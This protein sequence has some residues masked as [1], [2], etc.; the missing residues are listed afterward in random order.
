[1]TSIKQSF[2]YI[3][4]MPMLPAQ[5]VI[6]IDVALPHVKLI[7]AQKF[8]NKISILRKEVI[9]CP[10]YSEASEISKENLKEEIQKKISG[11][12]QYPVAI[13]LPQ[14]VSLSQVIDLP[15]A[16]ESDVKRMIQGEAHRIA[17]LS[18]TKIVWDYAPLRPYGKH[19]H[20]FWIS[21]CQ[22]QEI[23]K[24]IEKLG[25]E[26]EEVREVMSVGNALIC[27]YL[28]RF[29]ETVSTIIVEIGT[30]STTVAI[31]YEG[32]GVYVTSFALGVE[33]LSE[34]ISPQSSATNHFS[35]RTEILLKKN[36]FSGSDKSDSYC[37]AIENWLQEL[38]RIVG[39]WLSENM[40]L[41]LSIQSFNFVLCGFGAAQ[42]GLV[43]YLNKIA[44]DLHFML[45]QDNGEEV[46]KYP[47]G[48]FAAAEG[49][50]L[51]ALGVNKQSASLLP[52][53]LRAMWR[54]QKIAHI[55]QSVCALL[56]AILII[57]LGIGTWEVVYEIRERTMLKSQIEY[58]LEIANRLELLK[59]QVLKNYERIRPVLYKK[60]LTMDAVQALD[61]I[62]TVRSNKP[63]WFVVFAD[64]QTYFSAPPLIT[65]NEPPPT[66]VVAI[67]GP[68]P[69][70]PQGDQ[71]QTNKVVI[72]PG[73]V[74][75]VCI[76]EEGEALRRSLSQLVNALKQWSRFR[77]VDTVPA[78]QRRLLADQRTILPEK[79]FA[80]FMEILTNEFQS[81]QQTNVTAVSTQPG[82]P[83]EN[84][85][86]LD[87]VKLPV[88]R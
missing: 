13:T 39:E 34:T 77:N 63:M 66:N 18:Q 47:P 3:L 80:I 20:S 9:E 75:E 58:G 85:P 19:A 27:S 2:P 82:L 68:P 59:A 12:G 16:A 36:L 5:R 15:P 33:L 57:L 6:A 45:W 79:H 43:E 42:P 71:S 56:I 25:I 46:K 28:H 10:D 51:Q 61:L 37:A 73:F 14:H 1:M 52:E 62:A 50:A 26:R 23:D 49:L 60:Q 35:E 87:P 81:V 38:L 41:R 29:P 69:P 55:L 70:P 48:F 72:K 4:G 22:E 88:K 74:T 86:E 30:Q 7:L 83:V 67:I 78:E 84:N 24:A 11:F 53:D 65:T 44:P 40:E 21:L 8:L 64:E 76:P 32:Q 17:G 54:S 31:L